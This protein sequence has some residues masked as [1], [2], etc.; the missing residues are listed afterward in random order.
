ML[1]K[2]VQT[3]I[4]RLFREYE[5]KWDGKL[6]RAGPDGDYFHTSR[7]GAEFYATSEFSV[8]EFPLPTFSNAIVIDFDNDKHMDF[9]YS[10]AGVD[11]PCMVEDISILLDGVRPK[12]KDLG[13]DCL[14]ING[15]TGAEVEGVPVEVVKL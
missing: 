13:F 8:E 7:E 2:D 15:E 5:E 1:V 14:I 12:L 9:L 6:Y 11:D 4:K 10:L 3:T